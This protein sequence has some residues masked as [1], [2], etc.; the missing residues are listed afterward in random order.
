MIN[1]VNNDDNKEY[2]LSR[3]LHVLVSLLSLFCFLK[4]FVWLSEITCSDIGCISEFSTDI[5]EWCRWHSGAARASSAKKKEESIIIMLI[6]IMEYITIKEG[7]MI[8]MMTK[9]IIETRSY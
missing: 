2:Q 4:L 1:K 9:K 8:T 3:L 5:R 7:I 6:I